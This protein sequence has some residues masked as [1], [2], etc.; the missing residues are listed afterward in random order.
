[1]NELASKIPGLNILMGQDEFQI[2]VSLMQ[3]KIS[4]TMLEFNKNCLNWSYKFKTN[5]LYIL[6]MDSYALLWKT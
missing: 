6:G 4:T 5:Y 1:M 3:E 2:E